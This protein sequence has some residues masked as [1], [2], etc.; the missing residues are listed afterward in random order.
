MKKK[1]KLSA[2]LPFIYSVYF[3]IN[4]G[5]SVLGLYALSHLRKIDTGFSGR[6]N[7]LSALIVI[8]FLAEIAI[9]VFFNSKL[10]SYVLKPIF[11][12]SRTAERFSAGEI[13]L[14]TDIESVDT[15]KQIRVLGESLDFAF[16][17]LRTTVGEISDILGRMSRGDFTIEKIH[18]YRG[19]FKPISDSLNTIL[20]N[21]N[22]AF[23]AIRQSG[24]Q[25]DKGAGQ[26]SASAQQLAQGATEQAS[27][28]EELSASITDITNK[29]QENVGHI[30]KVTKYIDESTENINESNAQMKNML[31]AMDEISSASNEIKKIIKVIDDIAFQTNILALNAA[32]EAARA[33]E[34]GKGFAVVADEVRSLAGKS[35]NAAKNTT[36]LINRAID[37]VRDG[38]VLADQTAKA[39]DMASG[40][41]FKI[42]DTVKKI[43]AASDA[44]STSLE[45][46][47]QAVEQI[48]S[49]I[50]TNSATAEESAAASEELSGEAEQLEGQLS[51]FRIRNVV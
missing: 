14:H 4:A 1:K 49:V 32:V 17:N 9:F 37:K 51:K 45:E 20:G 12:L 47:N 31:T 2:S 50:Q 15:I 40:R 24:E 10:K 28:A 29:V 36:D 34:A 18:D 16:T 27:S 21:M 23:G 8:L 48:S 43:A 11:S 7:A 33:G 46:I 19:D 5:V 6:A 42:N 35:A 44:Q 30:R 3:L 25:V 38:T 22:M 41:A 26:V 39:L 13:D